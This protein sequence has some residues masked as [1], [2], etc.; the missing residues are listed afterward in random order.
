M[1]DKQL[2]DAS[3]HTRGAINGNSMLALATTVG[4]LC[5][6]NNES[7]AFYV[8][9]ATYLGLDATGRKAQIRQRLVDWAMQVKD[10]LPNRYIS[11]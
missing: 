10:K 7:K 1:N 6:P 11:R 5:V 8:G 4:G 3:D 9:N 2:Q